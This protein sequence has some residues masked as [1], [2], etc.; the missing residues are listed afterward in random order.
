M[1]DTHY[2]LF[3]DSV[4]SEV[5]L[6]HEVEEEKMDEILEKL[7]LLDLK[8]RHPMSLSGGQKQRVAIA[9]ALL[10]DKEVLV[11]DEPTSGLDHR[12]MK[13]FG[14]LLNDL[15][16]LNKVILVI[17]HDLELAAEWCDSIIQL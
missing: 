16:E 6:G 5:T 10:S 13:V 1:Q 2:Q 3:S 15:K 17:T 14:D 8:D 7:G 9:S 12:N 4:E 11:F